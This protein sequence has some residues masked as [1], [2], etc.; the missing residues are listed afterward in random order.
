[1]PPLL[2]DAADSRM[3]R[4]RNQNASEHTPADKSAHVALWLLG[5]F[6]I[7]ILIRFSNLA[8]KPAWMDEV[9]TTLFSLGNS[10]GMIP[11]NEVISL[12]QILRPLQIT[13]GAS[14]HNV[15]T[16]LLI[17][18]NH[19]PTYFVLAY[20][21]MALFHWLTGQSEGY[22]S[23]WAARALPAF[24]GAL[25]VPAI[26]VL[27]WFSFHDGKA[28]Q[29]NRDFQQ[30]RLIA[31]LCALLMA[32][33][34]FGIF[35]AQEA[36]HYSLAI[37][38]VIASLSCFV[39]A[40]K[41][42]QQRR[43]PAWSLVLAWIVINT[44]GLTIHFFCGLTLL[45]EG[46]TILVM[47]IQQS[48]NQPSLGDRPIWRTA[49]WIRLYVVVA[50]TLAG[51]LLWLP[52][53]INF[54]GSPQ[55]SFLR[56]G[57]QSW[58][59][60]INPIVQSLASWL[61]AVLSPVTRGYGWLA[62]SIIVISCIVLLGGYA[63]WLLATLQRSLRFQLRQPTL[64]TGIQAMGGFFIMANGLFLIICY[65]LGFDI[66]RGHRY[67]FVFFPSILILVG[68]GLAPFWQVPEQ[69]FSRV[70]LP[71]MKK[72]M[73]GKAFVATVIGISFFGTQMMVH[74]LS[75]LKFYSADRLVNLIQ[76]TST[77]PVVVGT[78]TQI[79]TQPSVIG[80]ELMSVAWEIQRNFN[81]SGAKPYTAGPNNPAQRWVSSP[82]FIIVED[83]E[84]KGI[85]ADAR[86]VQSIHTLP[87]P[88]DLWLLNM[89]PD[90]TQEG[91]K[92][93]TGG[94][95]NKGSFSYVHYQCEAKKA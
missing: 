50:G 25:A 42:L 78:S 31:L 62:V 35:M 14:V 18:D 76:E 19:P 36:R 71:L 51:A 1:M 59:F 30:S 75:N 77:L 26:Y 47:L 67:S 49:A 89:S 22:A 27:A 33:S 88:F 21:W 55:T 2:S 29:K 81:P 24:L 17:E 40:V 60:W 45:A 56:A 8:A 61:Y 15:V 87:R 73:S 52:I 12:E 23:L 3:S 70:K 32:I 63:P 48:L 44:L 39:L 74:N 43:P 95:A 80:I 93:P 46:L 20:G 34:P 54:Y 82:R 6:A 65:S 28:C 84:S 5:L 91:C 58:Q 9:A 86:L 38:A 68:V 7:A 64:R 16:H 69:E 90:L 72:Y 92:M 66:T 41:A 79:T 53:L 11:L 85:E 4:D 83:N 37:L 10:S 13:P 94:G 57:T